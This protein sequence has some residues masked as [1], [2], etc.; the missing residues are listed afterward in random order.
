M[1]RYVVAAMS[2]FGVV[3]LAGTI[4]AQNADDAAK[5]KKELEL[6]TRE[7]D[8]LKKENDLLK[9]EIVQLKAKAKPMPDSKFL[10]R[11]KLVNEKGAVSS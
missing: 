2:L 3:L 7:M 1:T 5:L 8:L 11:W 4:S 6:L 9:A 10:G